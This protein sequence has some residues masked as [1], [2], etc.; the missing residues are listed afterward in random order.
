ML[1]ATV[2]GR[3]PACDIC[4]EGRKISRRHLVLDWNDKG[5]LVV[6]DLDS[7]NGTHVAGKRIS[8]TVLKGNETIQAG[9]WQIRTM[10]DRRKPV[11][12]RQDLP[13]I[14]DDFAVEDQTLD[15]TDPSHAKLNEAVAAMRA[16]RNAVW[17]WEQE[18]KAPP[19][20]INK[21]PLDA[22]PIVQRLRSTS[23][24]RL[25][26]NDIGNLKTLSRTLDSRPPAESME[27]LA[28]GLLYRVMADLHRAL[29]LDDFLGSIASTLLDA[30]Q[31]QGVAILRPEGA[32]GE[33]QPSV[34]RLAE[35]IGSLKLSQTVV[36][37]AVRDRAAV[38][39]ANAANDTR[40][41]SGESVLR[42]DL[43]AVLCVPLL[44]ESE[45]EGVI[46]V[47]RER[48]FSVADQELVGAL[49]HIV[50]LGIEQ[51]R[52][53][54]QVQKEAALRSMLE[55]FH[56]PEVVEKL[57]LTT[58]GQ[59][60]S[61]FQPF[62]EALEATI[63]FCDLS[64][65]TAFSERHPPARI[66]SLLNAYLS[67]MTEVIRDHRGTVDK[68]IGDAVMAIFGAPFP[69]EDD[70]LRA[71]ACALAMRSA[72]NAVIA[73]RPPEERLRVR[74][75]VNTGPVV[76]GLIGSKMQMQYTALGDAVNVASRL[77]AA[78]E[79][80]Q[81]LIGPRTMQLVAGKFL[82]Q[83]RGPLALKGKA[84][85]VEVFEVVAPGAVQGV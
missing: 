40:F 9:E 66:A 61:G 25:D 60:G 13:V 78:A 49:G 62:L 7:H 15:L 29:T 8:E 32:F 10:A 85:P 55:R 73:D 20:R 59:D 65:F 30:T 63:V 43:R 22:N 45:I 58:R 48:P 67:R 52:M 72:F 82:I 71:V 1:R 6:R 51:A 3:D 26:L 56:T 21:L 28:L 83:K 44:R 31:G 80:G 2:V 42:L 47:T 69:A 64:S 4:L 37:A 81:I 35:R 27:A 18:V 50:G 46:Y 75:G 38:A 77:E 76:A 84:E 24:G 11:S 54:D 68:Y 23:T 41:A 17:S 16:A 33:M 34:V 70:A 79:P 39:A 57:M 14:T 36:E 5:E 12:A 74:I 53:R 19:E